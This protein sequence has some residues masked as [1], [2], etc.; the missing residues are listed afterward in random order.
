[1]PHRTPPVQ[2][3]EQLEQ[4]LREFTNFHG[5]PVPYDFVGALALFTAMLDNLSD[6]STDADYAALYE[7]GFE[8]SEEHRRVLERLL[9]GRA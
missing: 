1:M 6:F 9:G 4:Y 5:S 8:L 2:T 3:F 7:S